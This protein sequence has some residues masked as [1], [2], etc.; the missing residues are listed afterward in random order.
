M[1]AQ[2]EAHSRELVH[3]GLG[4][5]VAPGEKV[6]PDSPEHDS[7]SIISNGNGSFAVSFAKRSVPEIAA[8]MDERDEF[9]KATCS[10]LR[11]FF[12]NP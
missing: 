4:R 9:V 7:V 3:D 1:D 12:G 2:V 6:P 5:P 10:S 8:H 11:R